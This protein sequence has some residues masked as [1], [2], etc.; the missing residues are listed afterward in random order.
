LSPEVARGVADAVREA[1][2]RVPTRWRRA[3]AQVFA[4]TTKD[5]F[6]PIKAYAIAKGHEDEQDDGFSP[7]FDDFD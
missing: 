6:A 2:A 3:S 1:T 5:G 7:L 4:F